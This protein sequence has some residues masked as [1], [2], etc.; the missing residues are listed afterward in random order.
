[1]AAAQPVPARPEST[2]D[3]RSGRGLGVASLVL[4]VASLVAVFSFLLFPLALIGGVIGVVLGALALA[5]K[6]QGTNGQAVAGII[7]SL[8]ALVLAITLTVRVGSWARHNRRPIARLSS[9]LA[10]ANKDPAVRACFVR[11]A[12]EVRG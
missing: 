8:L 11:F 9:C 6:R 4:G 12:N 10:K 3:V 1:M 2:S 7:C 5:R